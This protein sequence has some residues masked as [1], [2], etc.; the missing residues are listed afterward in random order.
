MKFKCLKIRMQ[1][2]SFVC[3]M[4][5]QSYFSPLIT[6]GFR[7]ILSLDVIYTFHTIKC[8]WHL[9]REKRGSRLLYEKR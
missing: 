5:L 4:A 3:C 9:P 2:C 1:L 7:M 6:V 8:E